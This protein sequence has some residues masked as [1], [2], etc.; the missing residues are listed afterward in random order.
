[1]LKTYENL[2]IVVTHNSPDIC[3]PI[4]TSEILEYY[5]SVDSCLGEDVKNERDLL[6]QTYNILKEKNN[7]KY[8]FY[9]HFHNT[10]N[11]IKNDT[12]FI[13]IDMNRFYSIQHF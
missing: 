11:D 5:K 3:L 1:M 7:L 9:G 12:K 6:T 13:C 4:G 2:D 8:W 10:Y